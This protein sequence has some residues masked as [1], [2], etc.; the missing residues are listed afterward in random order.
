MSQAVEQSIKE[1]V[2]QLAKVQG[3][4]FSDTWQEVVLERWLARLASSPYR[5]NFI[6]KGAMCLLNYVNL[7]RETRDL[8]FLIK[9]LNASLEDIERYFSEVSAIDLSDGFT[10]EELEVS[11]LSHIH[12]KY[13]GN[14]VSVVGKL[15]KTRTK[16]FMDLGI[17]DSVTPKEITM[18]LLSTTKA[19]LFEKEIHLWAYPVE[20]IFAEKL[21]TS[22]SRGEQNSRMKDY[23]D[24][25]LL[26]REGVIDEAK[27]T[28][29]LEKTF[30]NRG[31]YLQQINL[32]SEDIEAL[33]KQWNNYFRSI[34]NQNTQEY[35]GQSIKVIIDEINS[36][37]KKIL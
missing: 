37:L 3:R 19:P 31:T 16:I 7:D 15:G 34:T 30:K 5:E 35:L 20:S 29:S 17:G 24:L 12:M 32:N 1:K 11:S 10:F 21:E 2:K 6:F 13:P 8:D 33:Q 14:Q 26:I 25:L 28:K 18:K 27:I 9:N 23:H 4:T 36:Y 22:L